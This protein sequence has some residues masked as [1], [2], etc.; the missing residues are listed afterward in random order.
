MNNNQH[1][2]PLQINLA[3]MLLLLYWA[4]GLIKVLLGHHPPTSYITAAV[5]ISFF[6]SLL[7]CIWLIP[8]GTN[9][10]RW[11]FLAWFVWNCLFAP[12]GLQHFSPSSAMDAIYSSVQLLLQ[13][14]ALVLLFLPT[15][16]RWLRGRERT[17]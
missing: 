1:L 4:F 14:V 12:W 16:K 6:G 9:W 10:A 11:L 5:F 17:A 8:R 3:S 2:R 7:L 15:A 13:F